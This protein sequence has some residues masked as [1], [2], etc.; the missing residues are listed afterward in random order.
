MWRSGAF[1]FK[2]LSYK[3]AYKKPI[4]YNLKTHFHPAS[5]LHISNRNKMLIYKTQYEY[6]PPPKLETLAHLLGRNLS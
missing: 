3:Q 2:T 6:I 4:H 5:Y 1:V